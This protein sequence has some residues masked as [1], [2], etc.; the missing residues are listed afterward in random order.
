MQRLYGEDWRAMLE[1]Q[2]AA[3]EEEEGA[4]LESVM[5]GERSA[6]A[7]VASASA[8]LAGSANT[9]QLLRQ[10]LLEESDVGAET[11][12]EH[13]HRMDMVID[14]LE[15]LGDPVSPLER[16]KVTF[17]REY[18]EQIV[19]KSPADQK[20][21]LKQ[22]LENVL[23]NEGNYSTLDYN[24]RLQVLPEMVAVRGSSLAPAGSTA[25]FTSDVGETTP[26][27]PARP[28]AVS[29]TVGSAGSTQDV[30]RRIAAQAEELARLRK[31][32]EDERSRPAQADLTGG[33]NLK[34]IFDA[35][36]KA[37]ATAV[38]G[39]TEKRTSTIQIRPDFK[40]PKLGDDGK[41]SRDIKEFFD[42]YE[43]Y[44][45]LANDGKGML[46]PEH[47]QT[48]ATCLQGTKLK[49][50]KLLVEKTS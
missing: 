26:E 16:R 6:E 31:D 20:A 35:Q 18:C 29:P 1:E 27:R 24:A 28:S 48:L 5:V 37:F 46:P 34:E 23:L 25:L 38:Q 8:G 11:T 33:V 14:Q 15:S 4:D 3:Q 41:S 49:I 9:V 36:A 22:T 12:A 2:Q 13:R 40:P 42:K 21:Y 32:L 30:E 50:Y 44:V 17:R 39:K 10:T 47:L 19:G 43:D 45:N 7:S